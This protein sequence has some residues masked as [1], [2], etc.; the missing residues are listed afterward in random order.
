V[1]S[2]QRSFP[3]VVELLARAVEMKSTIPAA[4][5]ALMHEGKLAPRYNPSGSDGNEDAKIVTRAQTERN[6]W[7]RIMHQK[8][9]EPV[10]CIYQECLARASAEATAQLAQMNAR[11]VEAAKKR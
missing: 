4:A 7:C 3:K 2:W 8:P 1:R 6:H 11:A 5:G 10:A 9:G